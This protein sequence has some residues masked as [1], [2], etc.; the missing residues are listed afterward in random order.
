MSKLGAK[1]K[2]AKAAT[3]GENASLAASCPHAYAQSEVFQ[4]QP[5]AEG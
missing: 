1:K 3:R 5:G 4:L 2:H